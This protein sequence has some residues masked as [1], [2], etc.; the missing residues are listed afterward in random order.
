M[1]FCSRSRQSLVGW[2][3]GE[4][5]AVWGPDFPPYSGHSSPHPLPRA[6]PLPLPPSPPLPTPGSTTLLQAAAT[7]P[8]GLGGGTPPLALQPGA[9]IPSR[10][11]PSL[12]EQSLSWAA[13]RPG[14]SD[15]VE[16]LAGSGGGGKWL[17]VA[18]RSRSYSPPGGRRA[19]LGFGS[20][21]HGALPFSLLRAQGGTPVA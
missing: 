13:R 14:N 2:C 20:A 21:A 7:H 17:R 11:P 1:C 19:G 12:R 18:L 10:R 9:R 15:C 3:R 6:A 4:G 16:L 8:L 5:G